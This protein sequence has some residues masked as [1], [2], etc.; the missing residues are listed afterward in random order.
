MIKKALNTLFF[1][2]VLMLINTVAHAQN[3]NLSVSGHIVDLHDNTQL[4][5]SSIMLL[6]NNKS[7]FSDTKGAFVL[8]DL[9][10]GTYTLYIEHIGC[11]PLEYKVEL[12]KNLEDVF[13][14]LEHH[15]QQLDEVT[16][17]S[18]SYLS[19]SDSGVEE[20]LGTQTIEE[21]SNLQ[22]AD[23]LS[24]I[25]GVSSLNTGNSISKPIINGLH[26]SRVMII[27][28]GVRMEDQ[29]WGS[30]HAPN[31]DVNTA[32]NI[33]VVKG[34]NALQYGGDAIGGI[35][36]TE[37]EKIAF[38]DSI[39]GSSILGSGTNGKAA[40]INSALVYSQKNG[41]QAKLQSSINKQGDVR[42][43]DYYLTNSGNQHKNFSAYVAKKSTQR[44]ISSYLSYVN[45]SIGILAASHIGDASDLYR[46]MNDNRPTVI[47]DFSYQINAPRQEVDHLLF[48][49]NA[50]SII[51]EKGKL[52]LQFDYQNNHRLEYDLRIGD[53]KNIPA[54]DL[55]LLSESLNLDYH[56][57]RSN[58]FQYKTGILGKY[59]FNYSNPD[60]GVKRLIPDYVKLQAGAYTV[61]DYELENKAGLE[62]GVRFDY[63]NLKSY[64]FYQKSLWEDRDYNQTQANI[65][66]SESDNQV[67][68]Y[69]QLNYPS[70]TATLGYHSHFGE[71]TN[72]AVNIT[73]AKRAPNPAE[74]FSEGLHHSASRIELGDL[75]FKQETSTKIALAIE[76]NSNSTQLS[77]QPFYNAIKD[78]IFLRPFDVTQTIRGFFQKWEY[79]QT[80]ALLYGVDIDFKQ[81]IGT[82]TQFKSQFSWVHGSDLS[83]DEPLIS[84]PPLQFTNEL[85]YHIKSDARFGIQS[86][87]VGRQ[88]RFPDYNFEIYLPTESSWKLID[89]S[90]PPKAYHLLGLFGSWNL[91]KS[92]AL[93]IRVDNLLNTSYRN[94]LNTMRY[95]TNEMGRN[96]TVQYKINY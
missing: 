79:E 89:I 23:V 74:L 43:P 57:Y 52:M 59:Q 85:S 58:G 94:Y 29:E 71:N 54:L 50:Y 68:T 63:I 33:T 64:K 95:F 9:C 48:K 61:V 84:I 65:V 53:H 55:E 5:G 56:S 41:L 19:I 38:K 73:R 25:S 83:K 37:P 92:S 86:K 18:K 35:I 88:N 67:L 28:N 4:E 47:E 15:V 66:V 31:M 87:F 40:F 80:S 20:T 44:G 76:H 12:S 72:F 22:L 14:Q 75:N 3:C 26:S 93:S 13:I 49:L 17:A 77:I 11:K 91:N 34:A 62:F 8:N 60:T 81:Q 36:V 42:S 69:P 16:V 45:S 24:N 10:P 39:Y 70:L 2:F 30:E 46:A 6:N 51:K 7:T 90:T 21:N 1:V 78:Y 32:S 82:N 96:I 27:N